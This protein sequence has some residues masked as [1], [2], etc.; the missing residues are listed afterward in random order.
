MT[1]PVPDVS[2]PPKKETVNAPVP[3]AKDNA[4]E[5]TLVEKTVEFRIVGEVFDSFIIVEKDGDVLFID[6]HALH[7]RMNFEKL[8]RGTVGSQYLLS[9]IVVEFGAAE[10]LIITENAEEL[11]KAGF[12]VEDFGGSVIVRMIPQILENSD[13]EYVLAKFADNYENLKL[14][15]N[16]LLDEFLHDCACNAS[17]ILFLADSSN[18]L[19]SVSPQSP[20]FFTISIISNNFRLRPFRT[21]S[22]RPKLSSLAF[23]I[24]LLNLEFMPL[25]MRHKLPKQ[26]SPLSFRLSY[27]GIGFCG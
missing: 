1:A 19:I 23:G 16:D 7:E 2:E 24:L 5:P 10:N 18:S 8:K 20:L 27:P 6:K 21:S 22:I 13:V 4:D 9:P 12:E 14:G 3:T 17:K 26:S 25:L 15:K 11:K